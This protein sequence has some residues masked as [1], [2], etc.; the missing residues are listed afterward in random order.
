ME[1][2]GMLPSKRYTDDQILLTHNCEV[3]NTGLFADMGVIWLLAVPLVQYSSDSGS[4]SR[5]TAAK[6]SN[7]SG[8][9]YDYWERN[10]QRADCN[11]RRCCDGPQDRMLKRA[12]LDKPQITAT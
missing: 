12:R 10:V 4:P 6:V 7:N 2:I 9:E 11:E 3:G 1:S 8:S 5:V